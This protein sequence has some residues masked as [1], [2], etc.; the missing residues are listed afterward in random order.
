MNRTYYRICLC[1]KNA[2]VYNYPG[3]FQ[4]KVCAFLEKKCGLVYQSCFYNLIIR[5]IKCDLKKV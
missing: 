2:N 5:K 1:E 3:Y 4:K